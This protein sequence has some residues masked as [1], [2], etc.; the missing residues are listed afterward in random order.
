MIRH[1]KT[2]EEY[3]LSSVADY[4]KHYEAR[5]FVIPDDQPNGWTAPEVKKTAAKAEPKN[6]GVT[7]H[8]DTAESND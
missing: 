3:G 5:G 6:P 1:P 8:R 7:V 2:G 4:R